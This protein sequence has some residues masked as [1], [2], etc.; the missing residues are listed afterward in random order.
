VDF[1]NNSICPTCKNGRSK[2]TPEAFRREKAALLFEFGVNR[3]S[4]GVQSWDNKLLEVLGRE[5]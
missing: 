4:L 3:I 2:R 5:T 1:S